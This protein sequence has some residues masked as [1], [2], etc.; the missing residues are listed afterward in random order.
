MKG[1]MERKMSK[2]KDM[3]EKQMEIRREVECS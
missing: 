2:F 1:G 3:R